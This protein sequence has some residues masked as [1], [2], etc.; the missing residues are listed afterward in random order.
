MLRS[1][2][3]SKYVTISDPRSCSFTNRGLIKNVKVKCRIINYSVIPVLTLLSIDVGGLPAKPIG[4]PVGPIFPVLLL[5]STRTSKE[6]NVRFV[7]SIASSHEVLERQ[8]KNSI[9]TFSI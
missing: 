6:A 8:I 7:S 9:G 3:P 4:C 1:F 5:V 2:A